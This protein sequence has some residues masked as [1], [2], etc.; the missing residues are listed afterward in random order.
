MDSTRPERFLLAS[1]SA[2][3]ASGRQQE[4]SFR[5]MLEMSGPCEFGE[6][7]LEVSGNWMGKIE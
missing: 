3:F 6:E 7:K 1:G 2:L 5:Y 4:Y